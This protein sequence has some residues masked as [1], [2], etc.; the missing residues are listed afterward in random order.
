MDRREF[1]RCGV[2][3]AG[4]IATGKAPAAV[5]RSLLGN[6]A[7]FTD[8]KEIP[9][10]A[11]YIQDGLI[12]MW[13]GIENKGYGRHD[14]T[15]STWVDLSGNQRDATLS[16]TYSWGKNYWQVKSYYGGG[17]ARWNGTNLGDDQTIEFVIAYIR[18]GQYSRIIAEGQSVASPCAEST[19]LYMYGYGKDARGPAVSLGTDIHKHTITHPSGG[20]MRYY[21]DGE[22]LWTMTTSNNSTGATYAYFGNR[23]DKN[24]GIDAKYYTMRRYNR[25]LADDEIALNYAIDKARFGL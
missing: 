17:M 1:I 16:G 9:T 20:Q 2:G 21:L 6:R 18:V 23:A 13:D 12:G 10:C 5:V 4:I 24:R 8:N 11:D 14:A 25:V 19:N 3:L 22:L 15:T 7:S